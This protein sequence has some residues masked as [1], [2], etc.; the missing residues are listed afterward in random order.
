MMSVPVCL[1]RDCCSWM[2]SWSTPEAIGE[3][4]GAGAPEEAEAAPAAEAGGG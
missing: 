3:A 4:E 2:D 1:G